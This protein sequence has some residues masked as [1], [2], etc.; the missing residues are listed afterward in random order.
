MDRA[1]DQITELED[2]TAEFSQHLGE[3][4]LDKMK[5]KSREMGNRSRCS[6]IS[7]AA[8]PEGENRKD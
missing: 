3:K 1:R 7:L 8:G 6:N 2:R 4:G 5:E